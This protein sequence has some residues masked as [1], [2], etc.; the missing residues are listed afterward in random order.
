MTEE[1]NFASKLL[2]EIEEEQNREIIVEIEKNSLIYEWI[3]K[4]TP[5][6]SRWR[7]LL[8]L[9]SFFEIIKIT[10]KI[11]EEKNGEN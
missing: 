6:H 4:F 1:E 2:Q 8:F 11:E 9:P 3:N 10:S 5:L 7:L